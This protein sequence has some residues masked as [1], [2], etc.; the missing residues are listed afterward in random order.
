MIE[1]NK[2]KQAPTGSRDWQGTNLSA[3]Q[4]YAW[5]LGIFK[6]GDPLPADDEALLIAIRKKDPGYGMSKDPT[7][8]MTEAEKKQYEKEQDQRLR[9]AAEYRERTQRYEENYRQ[10]QYDR[11]YHSYPENWSVIFRQ[12]RINEWLQHTSRVTRAT[13]YNE[14]MNYDNLEPYRTVNT[15]LNGM[16]IEPGSIDKGAEDIFY[17]QELP[18]AYVRT[19]WLQNP[20]IRQ[21]PGLDQD[22]ISMYA[23]RKPI[24]SVKIAAREAKEE[25]E[26]NVKKA[27]PFA[28]TS[29]ISAGLIALA[30]IA[31]RFT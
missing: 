8:V 6:Y 9:E 14:L 5:S 1:I 26:R 27:E 16:L 29:A 30:V 12:Q 23:W 24:L 18:W 2:Y 28:W 10:E 7:H 19:E 4:H 17:L 15:L 21:W 22:R 11:E 3:R 31:V 13:H 25:V 20:G